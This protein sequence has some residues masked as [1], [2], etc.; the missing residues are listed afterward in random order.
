MSEL[1]QEC[2]EKLVKNIQPDAQISNCEIQSASEYIL[3]IRCRTESDFTLNVQNFIDKFSN[4][5]NT[6]W[7]TRRTFPNVQKLEFRKIFVCQH[8]SFNK[9]KKVNKNTGLRDRNKECKAQIDVKIKKI[10][11]NTKRRDPYLKSGLNTEIKVGCLKYR[12]FS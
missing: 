2:L 10:T 4:A 1:N 7:I 5:T 9:V 11:R 12:V 6:N 3:V 8:N